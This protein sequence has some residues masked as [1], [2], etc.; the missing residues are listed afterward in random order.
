MILFLE[1]WARYPNAKPDYDTKNESYLKL[2]GTYYAMGIKNYAFM[3]ALHDQ[4][5]KGIDPFSPLLTELEMIK[6]AIECKV[7][8]WYYFREI[9]KVPARSGSDAVPLLA[10]RGNIALYWSFFN[11]VMTYL[12]Q[13]RQTGKS[14]S[15]D[16]LDSYLL[17]IRCRGTTIN[18]LTK[19]DALRSENIQRLKDIID[20]MP[21]YLKQRSKKDLD[22]T[23]L[24]NISSLGNW[25]KAHLPQKA[26]KFALNTGRGMSSPIFR[27]DEGPFQANIEISLPAA[28]AAG[29]A[30][31]NKA[32]ANNEPFGTTL[33]TTAGKKDDPDGRYFYQQICAAAEWTEKFFDAKDATEL[34]I[35]IRAVSRG[36]KEK[37]RVGDEVIRG[38]FA[39][40]ITM[41]HRQLGYDDAWLLTALEETKSVGDAA[42]RDFFNRWTSGSL[43]SPLTIQQMETI[44]GSQKE[45]MYVE[46]C[47]IGSFRVP[48][49]WY[50]PRDSIEMYMAKNSSILSAD[51]SDGGGGD[52]ISLSLTDVKTGMLIASFNVNRI[53]L[54]A[55][56][57]WVCERWIIQS[58]NVTLIPERK[59]SAIA[60]I[61]H[62]LLILPD[63]GIDPFKRIFNRIV[64]EP[65]ENK[66]AFEEIKL[67]LSRRPHDIYV[68]Y[69]KAFGWATSGGGLT[70][71][72]DLYS[73]TLMSAAR[74][75]GHMVN[76]K[77]TIDQ[78]L[79]LET[80]NGRVDHAPGEHDDAV[81]GWLLGHW[82]L[83]KAKN[84][85]Y[86]GIQVT[87]ILSRNRGGSENGGQITKEQRDQIFY[88]DKIKELLG[89][90]E[91]E[92]NE[93]ISMKI[94]NELRFYNSK[95]VIEENEVLS[96]DE[97]IAKTKETKKQNIIGRNRNNYGTGVYDRYNNP[98][99][100]RGQSVYEYKY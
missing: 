7:N 37:M 9:A 3:L 89:K 62:L 25:Y 36:L 32:R 47:K 14:I 94:E 21:F 66:T 33:T 20:E 52:D 96:L 42:D 68:R 45:P 85:V 67:P 22:N 56:S 71:R 77:T 8:P 78:I 74:N 87:D 65:D 100:S 69:K 86:Y 44:R 2:A 88:R 48:C 26:K 90:L 10:N 76:D 64:N 28:L 57:E 84:L 35:M 98:Y 92:Q 41:N 16:V 55:F 1:D 34:E 15:T 11:H 19:D 49:R 79:S 50:I 61:D 31:R 93:I 81:I 4:S 54:L 24:I 53:N 99:S 12:V 60:L 63:R 91:Q 97:L 23:E 58:P 82:M 51:T 72:S 27:V 70:S 43:S 18:L 38:E 75:C 39:V 83:T 29:V 30:M 46:D 95:L 40:N 5:L 73:T 17:N 6:I 59:S 80:R 13:I